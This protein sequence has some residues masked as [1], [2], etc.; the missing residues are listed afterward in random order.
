M[1]SSHRVFTDMSELLEYAKQD[2]ENEGAGSAQSNRYPIRFVLFENFNDFNDFVDKIGFAFSEKVYTIGVEKWLDEDFPDSLIT[3]NELWR[4]IVGFVKSMPANDIVITPFSE[5]ARFY[6]DIDEKEFESLIRTI[7]LAESPEQSQ[8]QHQRVYIPIIGM[9]NKMEKFFK[10]PNIHIWELSPGVSSENY[11][12]ILTPG[13]TY[14][15]KGIEEKHTLCSNL[16]SWL[17][18]WKKPAEIEKRIVCSS[19]SIFDNADNAQP[20]NA[21]SYLVCHNAFEFLTKGLE[22]D[23][24]K[25]LY[26]EED[27]EN[28]ER[29]AGKIDISNFNFDTFVSKY[30]AI[31]VVESATDFVHAW[32]NCGSSFDYWLLSVYYK[33]KS[34]CKDYLGKVLSEIETLNTSELFSAI[35]VAIFKEQRRDSDILQRAELLNEAAKHGAIITDNAEKKLDAKLKA[36]AADPCKGYNEAVRLL[37]PLTKAEKR[38]MIEWVGKEK[39]SL[40]EVKKKYPQLYS[41]LHP[42]RLKTPLDW[43]DSYFEEYR[44]SKIGDNS[45][46][47]ITKMIAEYNGNTTKFRSWYDEVK[48]VKTILNNRTDIEVIYW[49]DGLG[50]DWVP[51][52]A[53]LVSK[54]GHEGMYLNE[55]YI[56]AAELPTRTENNKRQIESIAGE[57]LEKIGDIDSFA[58]QQKNYPEYIAEEMQIV[59]EAVEEVLKKYNGK[60]IAFVSDHGITYLSQRSRGLNLAGVKTDHAGRVAEKDGNTASTDTNYLILDDGKTICALNHKSLGSKVNKGLGAHGGATPEEVL[61]PIIIVSN[62]KNSNIF[63]VN[64]VND[65]IMGNNPVVEFDIKGLSSVD[66]PEIEYNGVAYSLSEKGAGRY[67]SERINFVN[68][69]KTIVLRI[70]DSYCRKFDVSVN[71]GVE[72]EDIFK[73][74]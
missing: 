51:F 48:T 56:A 7:R 39:I 49:I 68:S 19:Q 6:D 42:Y 23:F 60:K 65:E 52:I 22:I 15:V 66:V 9:Q 32:F 17:E 70:G 16:Y 5:M 50:I 21:F 45:S 59:E 18:L 27:A 30:F 12:L 53:D 4:R 71:T 28:W 63:T 74:I 33:T 38:L 47:A 37:T 43:I 36:I 67:I 44:K 35:A 10:D 41:Y 8:S 29:L 57:R 20:D 40:N 1:M 61:V 73:N 54:H 31:S 24:G 55:I 3:S 69:C 2:K 11:R 46:E 58:H 14:G 72:E 26:K 34:D 64:I 25:I 62:Q 13:T